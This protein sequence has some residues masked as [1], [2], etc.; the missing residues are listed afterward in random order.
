MTVVE[1]KEDYQIRPAI[2]YGNANEIYRST[3]AWAH[4]RGFQVDELDAASGLIQL[5][6]LGETTADADRYVKF[7]IIDKKQGK[8][9]ATFEEWQSVYGEDLDSRVTVSVLVRDAG[10]EGSRVHIRTRWILDFKTNYTWSRYLEGIPA[11]IRGT[12]NGELERD[13][14]DWLRADIGPQTKPF[15]ATD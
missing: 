15:G 11:Q 6:T 5:R 14:L 13:L 4:L 9:L 12:S 1:A 8:P 7:P 3:V 2:V 10:R